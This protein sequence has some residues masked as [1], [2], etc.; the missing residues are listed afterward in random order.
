MIDYLKPAPPQILRYAFTLISKLFEHEYCPT[1]LKKII[2]VPLLKD[3][4]GDVHA[5][6]NHRPIALLSHFL[7]LYETILNNRLGSYVEQHLF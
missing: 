7:K 4:D 1:T 3:S 6:G 5:P 2:I